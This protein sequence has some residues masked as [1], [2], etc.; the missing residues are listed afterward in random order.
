MTRLKKIFFIFGLLSGMT[1]VAGF[2]DTQ[3]QSW[4]FPWTPQDPCYPAKR[5]PAITYQNPNGSFTTQCNVYVGSSV[6]CV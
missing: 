2:Q 1:Q 6:C 5:V 3:A 4:P